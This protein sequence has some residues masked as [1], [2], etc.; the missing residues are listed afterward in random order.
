M[1]QNI[2]RLVNATADLLA[3]GIATGLMTVAF[4]VFLMAVINYIWKR[5][6]GEAEGLKQA[7]TMLFG[8]VFGLFIMVTV[9]GMV[10][11]LATNLLGSDA[12]KKTIDKPQ[13]FWP[14][15]TASNTNK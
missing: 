3:N 10:N 5:R 15:G 8:S 14:T 11:F 1:L 13:T 12:N 6:N 4:I 2:T 7:G 9:W